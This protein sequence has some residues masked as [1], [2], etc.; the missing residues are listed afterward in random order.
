MSVPTPTMRKISKPQTN[1]ASGH[2]RDAVYE[3]LRRIYP[4]GSQT[5]YIAQSLGMTKKQVHQQLYA[6]MAD[7]LVEN[8]HHVANPVK[9]APYWYA[10]SVTSAHQPRV[11]A[12]VVAATSSSSAVSQVTSNVLSPSASTPT[13]LTA[14]KMT[15]KNKNKKKSPMDTV[16]IRRDSIPSSTH[17]STPSAV[18]TEKVTL[19]QSA[20]PRAV[21]KRT[22]STVIMSTD[23]IPKSSE[24]T[25]RC[26][27]SFDDKGHPSKGGRHVDT[28]R[29][30]IILDLTNVH[31]CS[32][33]LS[34]WRN[35]DWHV[36]AVGNQQT[37]SQLYPSNSTC[38]QA[39]VGVDVDVFIVYLFTLLMCAYQQRKNLPPQRSDS[40]SSRRILLVSKSNKVKQLALLNRSLDVHVIAGWDVLRNMPDFMRMSTA[41]PSSSSTRSITANVRPAPNQKKSSMSPISPVGQVMEQ[42]HTSEDV[43]SDTGDEQELLPHESRSYDSNTSDDEMSDTTE[44]VASGLCDKLDDLDTDDGGSGSKDESSEGDDFSALDVS[45][46]FKIW[47]IERSLSESMGSVLYRS[48]SAATLSA[49]TS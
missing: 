31:D 16:E 25:S 41:A 11:S 19:M 12:T 40:T 42:E 3:Y 22:E 4:H 20:I 5:R 10:V 13:Q 24:V 21:T 6:L 2:E 30:C 28:N 17:A 38:I 18:A 23:S 46:M 26:H 33:H 39:P 37:P 36:Y 8:R 35:N 14:M 27:S 48:S 34:S 9:S 15:T 49:T 44:P 45:E 43:S 32:K 29:H 47:E 7:E 1:A